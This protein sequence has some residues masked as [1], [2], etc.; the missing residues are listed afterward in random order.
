MPNNQTPIRFSDLGLPNFLLN[1]IDNLGF[2][3]PTPIQE[4]SIPPLLD[5]HDVIG[6]AQTGTG[7]TLAFAAPMISCLEGGDMGLVIA[8]TRELAHQIEETYRKLGVHATLLIGGAPMKPQIA[9]LKRA[10]DVVVA[11]PGR[12]VDHIDRRTIDLRCVSILVLDEAD[13]MLDMG[14]APAIKRIVADT[15]EDRQTMLFSA[16]MPKEIEKMAN[17]YLFKPVRVEVSKTGDTGKDIEQE[18]VV[19]ARDQKM[20]ILK[21]L[22]KEH[23]GT[24]LVFSRTRH[25]ARKLSRALRSRGHETAELHADRTLVQRRSALDGFKRGRYRILVATDIAARGIDVKDIGLVVNYDVPNNPEDYVHRIGRTGRA[26]ASGIAVT[27]ATPDQHTEI[28][29]IE[30]LLRKQIPMSDLSDGG[31]S[32]V[33]AKPSRRGGNSGGRPFKFRKRR[34]NR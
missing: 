24:V 2:T 32:A 11:T 7:K 31:F 25:G 18:L 26:G 15:P 20:S 19:V 30:K 17:S 13:R 12:L 33:E 22:L 16:T 3:T 10:P 34:N 21:T 14:F 4:K 27:L 9:A 1:Q 6:I 8:P 23:K 5:G 29:G 28:K